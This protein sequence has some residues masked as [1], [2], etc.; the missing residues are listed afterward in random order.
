MTIPKNNQKAP[1]LG[2]SETVLL[3]LP[4]PEQTL[5]ENG[6]LADMEVLQYTM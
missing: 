1:W 5:P 4:D 6:T 2:A 3:E